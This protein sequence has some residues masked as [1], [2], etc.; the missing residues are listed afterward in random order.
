MGISKDDMIKFYKG[1]LE[2]LINDEY[3]DKKRL[4]FYND[5]ITKLET[6]EVPLDAQQIEAFWAQTLCSST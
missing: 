3:H 6:S 4:K 5:L 2:A 1:E